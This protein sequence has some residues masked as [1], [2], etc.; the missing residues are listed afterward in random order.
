M[1][2]K[3]V[4]KVCSCQGLCNIAVIVEVIIHQ[5]VFKN[6]LNSKQPYIIE[7]PMDAFLRAMAHFWHAVKF[8]ILFYL[9]N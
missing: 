9:Y 6:F 3:G 1:S 4:L 8:D 2:N 5:F 7:W